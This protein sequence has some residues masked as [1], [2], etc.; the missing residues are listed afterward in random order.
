MERCHIGWLN[1]GF[2][3][4]KITEKN[5]LSVFADHLFHKT[6]HID[7]Y[8]KDGNSLGKMKKESRVTLKKWHEV[9]YQKK[10]CQINFDFHLMPVGRAVTIDELGTSEHIFR[11]ALDRKC[12]WSSL[13]EH[14]DKEYLE[15]RVKSPREACLIGASRYLTLQSKRGFIK[16]NYQ[17]YKSNLERFKRNNDEFHC[18]QADYLFNV[19]LERLAAFYCTTIHNIKRKDF[20]KSKY[21]INR[22][23]KNINRKI[24]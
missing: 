21:I 13:S 8:D 6:E 19:N 11:S 20:D 16:F 12:K 14:E 1:I 10:V 18:N 2:P 24:I 3:S 17:E 23:N 7:A 15:N 5:K 22:L 9:D 4:Y